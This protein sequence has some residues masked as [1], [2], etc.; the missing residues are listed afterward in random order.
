[1]K[2]YTTALYIR[3]SSEDGDKIE[4]DSVKNQRDL[5]TA[6]AAGHPDISRGT[7]LQFVDDGW[8]GTNFDRPGVQKMLEQI[9]KGQIQC[10]IVKDVRSWD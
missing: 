4:S 5:L 2:E 6:F 10:V 8:S 9:R 1:M 7:V 3:L